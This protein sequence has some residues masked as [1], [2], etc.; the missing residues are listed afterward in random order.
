MMYVLAYVIFFVYLCSRK[1]LETSRHVTDVKKEPR[2][3]LTDSVKKLA[4]LRD[5]IHGETDMLRAKDGD[6]FVTDW[7]RN[8][9]TLEYIGIWE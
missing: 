1:G 5:V 4:S 3:D 2:S 9:N 6:F 7:L 8:R